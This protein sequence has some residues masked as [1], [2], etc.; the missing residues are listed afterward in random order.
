MPT[1]RQLQASALFGLDPTRSAAA[2]RAHRAHARAAASALTTALKP[3]HIALITGPSGTGKSTLLRALA[4]SPSVHLIRAP[5]PGALRGR[6]HAIIDL[7]PRLSLHETLR[8]LARAGLAEAPLFTLPPRALSEGQLHRLSIAIAFA[9]AAQGP[10]AI[11]LLDEF[12]ST[13]DRPTAHALA[14]SLRR[15]ISRSPHALIAATA[16]DDLLEPL[17]PDH[18]L[19]CTHHAPP[20][21][22]S[23]KAAA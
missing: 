11:L 19:L 9:R 2:R 6:N 1:R 22:H 3:G 17:A 16:H 5:H 23:R 12:A 13:L 7:F 15:A 10:R 14:A 20:A 8:T 18:L 21:L 4:S